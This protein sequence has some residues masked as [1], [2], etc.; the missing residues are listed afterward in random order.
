M[1]RNTCPWWI[2]AQHVVPTSVGTSIWAQLQLV[3]P[4]HT[5]AILRNHHCDQQ[6]PV[7]AMHTDVHRHPTGEVDTLRLV[8]ATITIVYITLTQMRIMAQCGA[9]HT[10]FLSDPQQPARRVFQAYLHACATKAGRE[11][12]G[13]K[14]INRA[15][16][17][18][19]HQHPWPRPSEHETPNNGGTKQKEPS[20][21]AEGWTPPTILLLAPNGH[22][23]ATRTVQRHHAP[24]SI[25]KHAPETEVPPVRHND[26]GLPRTCWQCGPRALD[27]PWPLLHLISTHYH[28]PTA[29]ATADKQA[30]LSPLF[31]RVPPGHPA[32]VPWTRTPSAT[33][34]FT[35]ERADPESVAKEYDRCDPHRA[36]P[37]EAPMRPLQH[38]CPTLRGNKDD[39][40]RRQTITFQKFHPN[41]GYFFHLMYAYI[42]QGR[43]DRRLLCLTPRAQAIIA[44]GIGVYATPLLQPTQMPTRTAQG[45]PV[46]V[47]HPTSIARLPVPS[48]TDIIY[49]TDASRTQQRTPTVGC[50]SV[51]ITR[52]AD[53]LHVG[54]H[55]GATIFGASSHGEL[56][57]LADAITATPPPATIR[58]RNIWVVVD[59]TVDIYLS[60]RLADLPLHRALESGLTTQALGL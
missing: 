9:H 14:D 43:P 40:E 28:T 29:A 7:V 41:T 27:T 39:K 23:H 33:W 49:F 35:N 12:P 10:P 45:N 3:L 17:T 54:H 50:A 38:K 30:W 2:L 19:Q 58:P 5:H 4:H 36:G 46:Y 16:K 18:F 32:H 31:H 53:S 8:G 25:P 48:D 37:L 13:P 26:Q 47:Y 20:P 11:M 22:K 44:Q 34:T 15:Y 59:A 51:C 60:R 24:W 55:T 57:T 56:S 1:A 52:S 42:T 6:G 21:S